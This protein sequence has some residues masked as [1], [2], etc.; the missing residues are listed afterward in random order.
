MGLTYKELRERIIEDISIEAHIS[1]SV[2]L[3]KAGSNYR[4]SCPFHDE[5]T[6]SFMVSPTK[7]IFKCFGCG[8]AGDVIKYRQLKENLEYGEVLRSFAKELGLEIAAKDPER[9]SK[10][11]EM[12]LINGE[13][14]ML[15]RRE[16]YKNKEMLNYIRSRNI[17]DESIEKF[18][19]GFA[20][21]DIPLTKYLQSQG[22]RVDYAKEIG[23][24]I[25]QEWGNF[26]RFSN[27]LIFPIHD[28]KGS[29][30]G[31]A[32]RLNP[33]IIGKKY[34]KYLNSPESEIFSKKANLYGFYQN[35]N[36]I[37]SA[38]GVIL[39]EGYTDVISINQKRDDS[40]IPLGNMGTALTDL[41]IKKLS[42]FGKPVVVAG[43][44]DPGGIT[45][46]KWA[47]KQL[48][49]YV[50]VRAKLFPEGEDPDSFLRE[51][52]FDDF[53]NL[54]ELTLSEF[55][56]KTTPV[57][58]PEE[59]EIL[60]DN[61]IEEFS[62]IQSPVKK[63]LWLQKVGES[64]NIPEHVVVRKH[65]D[66]ISQTSDFSE[67][68]F[69][70]K[71]NHKL[72]AKYLDYLLKLN[73]VDSESYFE[74]VPIKQIPKDDSIFPSELLFLYESMVNQFKKKNTQLSLFNISND[75]ENLFS[76][77]EGE[78]R[79]NRSKIFTIYTKYP[80]LNLGS[81]LDIPLDVVVKLLRAEINVGEINKVTN[82]LFNQ[83]SIGDE[84]ALMK[85]IE[86]LYGLF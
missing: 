43:D 69:S 41:S 5:K 83:L 45:S 35:K 8:R 59:K 37:G 62:V 14:R 78:E 38:D 47:F 7:G 48:I 82:K 15:Y 75:C 79:E 57:S 22:L 44:N 3:R 39:V 56:I 10:L 63:F 84:D 28:Y 50:P 60:L 51:N 29:V 54:P 40:L 64:L 80:H 53:K 21:P 1:K 17:S 19:L 25:E 30:A 86:R 76:Y 24:I 36:N 81:E 20:N 72:A 33:N 11:D 27:R 34:A 70:R 85:E 71:F 4:G 23:L 68:F 61:I 16:L 65:T 9:Q 46:V 67:H 52:S 42:R 12:F 58:N 55:Y 2:T 31:F 49:N 74:E 66:S 77:V 6:P 32:G 26:D 73:L 13:V 18:E